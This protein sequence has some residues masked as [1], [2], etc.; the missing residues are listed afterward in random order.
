MVWRRTDCFNLRAGLWQFADCLI[1][2]GGVEN[3]GLLPLISLR[4]V[5]PNRGLHYTG[6]TT[7]LV[8]TLAQGF[9]QDT[10]DS[11]VGKR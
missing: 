3:I 9:D 1:Q 8:A 10:V 7:D 6:L 4:L 11:Q 5:F 2:E